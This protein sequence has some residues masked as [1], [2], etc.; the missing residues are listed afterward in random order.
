MEAQVKP[1]M[2]FNS[3]TASTFRIR[4]G[5][6]DINS[7]VRI[8][9]NDII[10]VDVIESQAEVTQQVTIT[11]STDLAVDTNYI[12]QV[13]WSNQRNQG[14]QP[15]RKV[16]RYTTPS[17][18]SSQSDTKTAM[19]A[20]LAAQI[21]LLAEI[22][23]T[24]VATGSTNVVFTDDAGYY[25]KNR[26]GAANIK[27]LKD[28]RG[29]GFITADVNITRAA[30]YSMGIGADLLA[31]G[32]KKDP[33]FGNY[34]VGEM[35]NDALNNAVAGQLY[36][37]VVFQSLVLKPGSVHIQ[38]AGT[39][40]RVTQIVLIDNGKGTATTNAATFALNLVQIL[41]AKFAQYENDSNAIIIHGDQLA[42][43]VG[44][45][46]AAAVV[47]ADLPNLVKIGDT[48]LRS[49]NVGTGTLGLLEFINIAGYGY[50]VEQDATASEGREVKGGVD[51]DDINFV[52]GQETFSAQMEFVATT[53][54]NMILSFGFQIRAAHQAALT[55][56]TDYGIFQ[57]NAGTLN[58]IG[59]TNT[60]TATTTATGVSI[61][62]AEVFTLI[63]KVN[64][65]GSVKAFVNGT[66]VSILSAASTPLVFDAGDTMIPFFRCTNLTA[67]GVPVLR[68]W[69]AVAD[70]LSPKKLNLFGA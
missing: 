24:A 68:K 16:I 65:D 27:L 52:V 48:A 56:Y 34:Y 25:G 37:T 42:L 3:T 59:R 11:R 66:E 13:S 1:T 58:T 7:Q 23:L 32:P 17:V 14:W 41:K 38:E 69:Y 51:A 54:A 10:A 28:D 63:I 55:S 64:V 4:G 26:D 29:N 39:H 44:I 19:F 36:T 60:G 35:N 62:N 57:M 9:L 8:R 21:N 20:A 46:G 18:I 45:N 2:L 53:V 33:T 12:L 49:Y 15:L 30:V 47:T 67:A 31:R 6:L 43:T 70:D 50:G 5:A 22:P 40:Q 61:A